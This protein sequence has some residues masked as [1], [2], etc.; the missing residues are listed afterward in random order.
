MSR[1]SSFFGLVGEPIL[2]S[3][4]LSLSSSTSASLTSSVRPTASIFV[5][6]PPA[7]SHSLPPLISP[8]TDYAYPPAVRPLV[9][10]DSSSRRLKQPLSFAFFTGSRSGF[11]FPATFHL[12]PFL[13]MTPLQVLFGPRCPGTPSRCLAGIASRFPSFRSFHSL[14]EYAAVFAGVT[15]TR[16]EGVAPAP[17]G[18]FPPFSISQYYE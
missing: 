15:A 17:R 8:V 9:T 16:V 7:P 3:T 5:N 12:L 13:G 6:P 1:G 11:L 18:A 14:A 10:R 4:L 2:L